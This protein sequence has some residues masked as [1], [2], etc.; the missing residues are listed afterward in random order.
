LVGLSRVQLLDGDF[1]GC[2]VRND[3][4]VPHLI[5]WKTAET[6]ALADVPDMKALMIL[7][8]SL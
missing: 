5:N 7:S 3:I 4:S 2:A 1:I 8:R 6:Y